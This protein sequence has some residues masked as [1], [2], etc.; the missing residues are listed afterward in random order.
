LR[1]DAGVKVMSL[2]PMVRVPSLTSS[3]PAI[4]RSV[5]DLPQPDGPRRIANVPSST[6]NE[7]SSTPIASPQRLVMPL[8]SMVDI[9]GQAFG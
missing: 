7:T 8:S 3:S 6:R 5:V 9:R 2:P 4:M 1:A